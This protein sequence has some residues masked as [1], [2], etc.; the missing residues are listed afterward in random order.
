LPENEK[1]ALGNSIHPPKM[2]GEVQAREDNTLPSTPRL[3]QTTSVSSQTLSLAPSLELHH[4]VV[5]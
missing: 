1:A 3:A 5:V 4:P 2:K